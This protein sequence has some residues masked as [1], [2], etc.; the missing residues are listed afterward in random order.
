MKDSATL[1]TL[2]QYLDNCGIGDSG[3]QA[4]APALP[5]L[6]KLEHVSAL[7]NPIDRWPP[8]GAVALATAAAVVGVDAHLDID[9]VSD[10]E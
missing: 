8:G 2:Y 5:H 6:P 1:E 9:P 10:D 4:L 3:A 7:G